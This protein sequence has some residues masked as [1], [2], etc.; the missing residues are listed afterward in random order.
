M[1]TSQP[2]PQS[3]NAVFQGGGVLGIGLIGALSV[4]EQR[5]YTFEHV[6]GTSAGAIAASLVASG[7]S[8]QDVLRMINDLPFE[9]MMDMDLLSKLTLPVSVPFH[10]I[11]DLGVFEGKYLE[12]HLRDY[13]AHAPRG[14]A[15]KFGA[16][17]DDSATDDRFRYRLQ[18]VAADLTRQKMAILPRDATKY[19]DQPDD[20]DVAHAVRMS[21]SIPFFF[22][23]VRWDNSVIVD[24]G[25]TS[26]FPLWLFDD[27]LAPPPLQTIGFKLVQGADVATADQSGGQLPGTQE[28]S[29]A[30]QQ[31]AEKVSIA[32]N[33]VVGP[34]SELIAMIN[35]SSNA[36]DTMYLADDRFAQTITIDTLGIPPADFLLT[37][38]D[39]QRLF[40][41]GQAAAQEFLKYWNPDTFNQRFRQGQATAIAASPTK[42]TR[43]DRVMPPS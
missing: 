18:V 29:Q 26:S 19:G 35:T 38:D 14:D 3:A 9:R 2:Q 33:I 7:Y 17:R 13:L 43:R 6:A 22:R 28:P 40:A 1:T 21:M 15:T 8:A 27:G 30:G 12:D 10:L 23:A 34:I 36:L 41:S 20:L 5:G 39:K 11:H 42:S 25:Q 4:M 16:L 24:G 31:L 37:R 32:K